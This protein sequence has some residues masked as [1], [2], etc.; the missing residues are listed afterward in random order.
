MVACAI[1]CTAA[2]G[3]T[4]G[5]VEGGDPF[6]LNQMFEHMACLMRISPETLQ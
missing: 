5:K 2:D 4:G 6:F 3:E 1:V